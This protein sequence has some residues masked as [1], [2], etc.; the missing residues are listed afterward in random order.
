MTLFPVYVLASGFQEARE[1][2]AEFDETKLDGFFDPLN[3][4][5]W[6]LQDNSAFVRALASYIHE[7]QGDQQP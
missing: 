5:I 3:H 7:E 4:I 2:M 1:W 6:S